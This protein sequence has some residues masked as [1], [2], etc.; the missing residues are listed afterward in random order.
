MVKDKV[1]FEELPVEVQMRHVFGNYKRQIQEGI[2]YDILTEFYFADWTR[3]CDYDK[4]TS[5]EVVEAAIAVCKKIE[6]K[7]NYSLDDEFRV[8]G[9]F[10][11]K[12]W[13]ED[14]T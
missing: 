14:F 9:C 5:E 10:E 1:N 6:E 12:D 7:Y 3:K 8:R 11:D 4:M 2:L 13:A